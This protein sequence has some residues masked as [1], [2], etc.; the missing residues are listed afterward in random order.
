[1]PNIYYFSFNLDGYF[2]ESTSVVVTILAAGFIIILLFSF[3]FFFL[4]LF[5][6]WKGVETWAGGSC[7]L[8][9]G[10][11]P[12]VVSRAIGARGKQPLAAAQIEWA[13]DRLKK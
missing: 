10:L 2:L 3:K 11:V 1:M 12:G 6:F 7:W 4:F 9:H 8:V 5:F 13:A